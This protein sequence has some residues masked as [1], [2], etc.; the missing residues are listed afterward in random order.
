MTKIEGH[1]YPD[2]HRGWGSCAEELFHYTSRY[3]VYT[4]AF[5]RNLADDRQFRMSGYQADRLSVEQRELM[6][7]ILCCP[8]DRETA[9]GVTLIVSSTLKGELAPP[10]GLAERYRDQLARIPRGSTIAFRA[11]DHRPDPD[12]TPPLDPF[13][14]LAERLLMPVAVREHHVEVS[15]HTLA[16]HL[17]SPVS[18]I[19]TNLQDAV[20]RLHNAGYL[21]RNHR[22]LTHNEAH[23]IA[24]EDAV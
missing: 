5:L 15:L 23:S 1:Y 21:V 3:Y 10:D 13:L 12:D 20:L 4:E 24:D 6:A 14:N 8:P 11:H 16:K 2:F 18:R 19:R 9:G 17:D 7:A 22:H